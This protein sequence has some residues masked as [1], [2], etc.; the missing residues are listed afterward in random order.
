MH[1]AWF[2]T[3]CV[4]LDFKAPK[5]KFYTVT[6][7]NQYDNFLKTLQI[8]IQGDVTFEVRTTVHTALLNEEDIQEI[9]SILLKNNFKGEYFIQNFIEGGKTLTKLPSQTKP[10]NIKKLTL[11]FKFTPRNFA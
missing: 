5:N 3:V 9:A 4:K 2:C 7:S 10:L 6:K 1:H 8:L 11:P